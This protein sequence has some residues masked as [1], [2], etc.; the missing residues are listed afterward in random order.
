MVLNSTINFVYSIYTKN[1]GFLNSKIENKKL[2]PIFTYNRN[3]K[4]DIDS[5]N[6]VF[7]EI[8]SYKSFRNIFITLGVIFI[9]IFAILACFCFYKYCSTKKH[10]NLNDLS[11]NLGINTTR[12]PTTN[13]TS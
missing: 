11:Q 9:I 5:F 10:I 4:V 2:Y 6:E 3:Y 12:E 1:Y 7:S 13:T 8:N